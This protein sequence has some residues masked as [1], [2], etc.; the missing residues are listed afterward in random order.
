MKRLFQPFRR[1]QW[2]LTFSY[3]WITVVTLVIFE[4]VIMF[5]IGEIALRNS[6]ALGVDVL[7]QNASII[8]PYFF[9]TPPDR[10]GL[11]SWLQAPYGTTSQPQPPGNFEMVVDQQGV[12]LASIGDVPVH[13]GN[14]LFT[15]L[16]PSAKKAVQAALAGKTNDRLLV[17]DPDNGMLIEAAPIIGKNHK[18]VGALVEKTGSFNQGTLLLFIGLIALFLSIPVVIFAALIGTLFGFL[19]ARNFTRRIKRLFSVADN[20][21]RG[22]FSASA[23]DTSSDELGQLAQRLNNM[24]EQL[25]NLLNTRQK[26]AS[27]EARNR[28]ARDLH[29]SVKQQVFAVSM[30]VRTAKML[31]KSD[32]DEAQ[33]H[34]Q[35]A[36][37]LV[38]KTQQELTALVRELRPI[39]L[40]NK[41]FVIALRELVAD[42]SR[43]TDIKVS[44]RIAC[45]QALSFALE[46]ALFRVVQEALAN[47]ARHSEATTVSLSL[48]CEQDSVQLS[49]NDNGKGFDL[50]MANEVGLGLSSMRER[51]EALGGCIEI[52]SKPTVG[53]SIIVQYECT[54]VV[55]QGV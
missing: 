8:A 33:E 44:L 40:E 24:A 36:E 2:K 7:K 11:A 9:Q 17:S 55:T 27:L 51:I 22:D 43:Q 14:S 6:P 16:S 29:D 28:L 50:A 35:E 52:K 41:G 32:A 1:L 48:L 47:V 15:S 45:E 13:V 53:T 37:Q 25:Q 38:Q 12:I 42:W 31:L 18:V 46:E 49:I 3:I 10:D 19:T 26:L 5:V 34:L 54:H 30:Q 20:W 39:A 4:L 23:L 21:S